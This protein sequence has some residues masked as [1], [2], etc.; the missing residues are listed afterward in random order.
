MKLEEF[1]PDIASRDKELI[2]A[3]T[4][5]QG[6]YEGGFSNF[7][8]SS[9]MGGY[10]R[11]DSTPLG[12][13]QLYFDWLRTAYAY[14][15]MFI[16]DLYLLAFDIAELR[17]PILSLRGEIFR[18]GLDEWVAAFVLKCKQCGEEYQEKVEK[19]ERCG[20]KELR[21]PNKQQIEVI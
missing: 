7:A 11:S 10:Q 2:K 20:S 12:I 15:R 18:K 4:L 21:K 17:I 13:E 8:K 19:C 1:V 14:R 6:T 3:N 5:L 9:S 16:Q